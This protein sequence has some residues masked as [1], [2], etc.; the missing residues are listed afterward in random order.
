MSELLVSWPG[1]FSLSA[2]PTGTELARWWTDLSGRSWAR[3]QFVL[4]TDPGGTRLRVE[5]ST[6][7]GASW[8]ALIP[9]TP[10]AAVG[11]L[12]VSDVFPVVAQR[13]AWLRPVL[14][15]TL[16]GLVTVTL[17]GVAVV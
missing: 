7:A 2:S 6:D 9:D 1:G 13:E 14:S 8:N 3:C 15:A 5:Y 12:T 11:T 16:A 17:V 4:T 10:P